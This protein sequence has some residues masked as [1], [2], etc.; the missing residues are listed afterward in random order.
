MQYKILT[1]L[2]FVCE[3]QETAVVKLLHGDRENRKKLNLSSPSCICQLLLCRS[4]TQTSV[5]QLK[6][7]KSSFLCESR[8]R[9]LFMCRNWPAKDVKSNKS[10][11]SCLIRLWPFSH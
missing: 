7:A 8:F 2:K 6:F 4:N 5:C 9:A 1:N 3:Q 11:L 10:N